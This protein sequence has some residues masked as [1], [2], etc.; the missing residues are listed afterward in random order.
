MK[1]MCRESGDH[2]GE[3][4][5]LG[6]KVSWRGSPPYPA[7]IHTSELRAFALISAWVTTKATK[8][9]LGEMRGSVV[10]RM[11]KMSSKSISSFVWADEEGDENGDAAMRQTNK[12]KRAAA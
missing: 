5:R 1:V 2:R 11:P 10:T 4:S 7:T 9:P 8:L 6:E 12:R 3:S